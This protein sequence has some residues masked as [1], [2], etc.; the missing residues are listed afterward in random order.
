MLAGSTFEGGGRTLGVYTLSVP[1]CGQKLSFNIPVVAF[2]AAV[3]CIGSNAWALDPDKHVSQY[4]HTSWRVQ[5]GSIPGAANT[6]AQSGDGYIW[7]G[8]SSGLVRFDGA[9]FQLFTTSSGESLRSP[10]IESLFADPDGS[11]WIGTKSD[12]EHWQNGRLR[13]FPEQPGLIFGLVRHILRSRDGHIWFARSRGSDRTGPV[14]SLRESSLRCFNQADGISALFS[15]GLLEDKDG[16]FWFHDDT[17]VYHWDPR[18]RRELPGGV[19]HIGGVDNLQNITFDADGSV[20]LAMAQSAAGLGLVR[21]R[22][23][24]V[25]PFKA[26]SI[27]GQAGALTVFLD[28]KG[29]VWI[30]TLSHGLY[31]VRGAQ[32][33][34]YGMAEGLSDE[35]V[36]NFFEDR[37]GNIW[38][39]TDQGIDRFR[40]LRVTTY[41]VREGLSQDTVHAVMAS[42]DGAVWVSNSTSLDVLHPDGGVTSFRGGKELPGETVT[43]LMEDRKKRVW[44]G[45][46]NGL[47]VFDGRTFRKM[48]RAGGHSTGI[49][50]GM[51][52]DPAGE[53]WGISSNDPDPHAALLHFVNDS[54]KEEIP[55]EKLPIARTVAIAA[56]PHGGVWLPLEN[57]DI[58][59]LDHDRVEVVALHR[60]PHT[61]KPSGIEVGPDDS[62]LVAFP[63]GLTVIRNGQVRELTPAQG[64]PCA[65]IWSMTQANQA[66][67]LYSECGAV[68]LSYTELDRWWRDATVRP[69]MTVLNALDGVLAVQPSYFPGA[70]HSPD[71]R[72]W[73]ANE[74][75]LQMIDPRRLSQP[76][77]LPPVQIEQLV[78]DGNTYSM[79][80][81]LELPP[82]TRNVQFDYTSPSFATPQRVNFRYKLE[83]LDEK[84]VEAG[85]RRQAFFTNLR[86]GIYQ[87][88]VSAAIGGTPWSGESA[89][90]FRVPPKFYQTSWFMSLCVALGLLVLVMLF[91]LR[92]EAAKRD[93]HAK[94][95][96]RI[97]ERERIARDLHDHLFQNVQGVL[98]MIDNSTNTLP[99]GHPTRSALKEALQRSDEVMADS[100]ERV[101]DLRAAG[102]N[103]KSIGQAL[104][105][106]GRELQQLHPCAFR[107]VEL[108][109][110]QNLHPVVFEEVYCICREALLN[111]FKHSGANQVE[112]EILF[113][114]DTFSVRITDDGTGIDEDVLAERGKPGHFGLKGM[115]ERA[116]E[117][118]ARI[119]I[120]SK[121]TTGTSI[122]LSMPKAVACGSHHGAWR[123]LVTSAS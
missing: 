93:L 94:L 81:D 91:R 19:S 74:T 37:E 21:D 62:I 3:L 60:V 39:A 85:N 78:A 89:I 118:G 80:P 38:V 45:L 84:W 33:E 86:P 87:F 52:E 100:R 2:I 32:V 114:P 64:L 121:P 26:G 92:V 6:I 51:I 59:H 34:H 98:L 72:V 28:S 67:W 70:A 110:V 111:A 27:A 49:M 68:E 30:G 42:S 79:S 73:F 50:G 17:S 57:G 12:L 46:D 41:S 54:L 82:L 44:V 20:L 116:K 117:I 29:S 53:V 35:T 48:T 112:M 90:T 31:R 7:I 65:R 123:W 63:S 14:C 18:T 71:G 113:T 40:D 104:S 8:T 96:V 36:E 101:L 13:H 88:H 106:V 24:L 25:E 95:Q 47:Q 76:I 99:E 122:E 56:D 115:V 75:V 23:G 5:D 9:R 43:S 103:R 108:G 61:G 1:R 77:G 102:L 16:S 4:G 22:N 11:L 58:A 69:R 66:L 119:T 120:R 83:G 105:D 109:A 15:W 10:D 107:A 97:D 55:F